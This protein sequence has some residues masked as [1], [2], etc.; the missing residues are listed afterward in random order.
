MIGKVLPE[1]IGCKNVGR[2]NAVCDDICEN[3]SFDGKMLKSSSVP[4]SKKYSLGLFDLDG[5]VYLGANP[6]EHCSESIARA[7]ENGMHVC[8]T[9]N[10]PSRYPSVIAKQLQSFGLKAGE[11]DVITSAMVTAAMLNEALPDS[12]RVLVAGKEHLTDELSSAGFDLV[13]KAD[14]KPDAVVQSWF[15][16]I[17]WQHL[18][19][20]AYAIGNGARYFVT[21]KDT[22]IPRESGIA[23]GNGAMQV[24]V[25]L[26]TGRQPEKSAGKPEPQMY[27]MAREIFSPSDEPVERDLSLPVGDRLDTDIEAANRGGYDSLLVLT[28]VTKPEDV[29][30][31]EKVCRPTYISHDL[32]GLNVAHKA[33][34]KIS[35]AEI[36]RENTCGSALRGGNSKGAGCS[37]KISSEEKTAVWELSDSLAFVENNVLRVFEFGTSVEKVTLLDSLR[38]ACSAVWEAADEGKIREEDIKL[39]EFAEVLL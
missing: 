3:D 32:R 36:S 23:P 35:D 6:I 17:G 29:I 38:A 24:P 37:E 33:P 7:E 21:N 28:G 39:P 14:E 22:T 13:S 18:S 27:N 26:A 2:E 12:A 15:P 31:A 4:L 34:K 20:V 25:M 8:Y 5:V 9:T 10:N 16:E 1:N 19:Q 11:K 30:R